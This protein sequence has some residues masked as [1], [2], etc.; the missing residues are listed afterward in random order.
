MRA[1]LCAVSLRCVYYSTFT[2]WSQ[3]PCKVGNICDIGEELSSY[4]IPL[5]PSVA[6]FIFGGCCY[7]ASACPFE[8][9]KVFSVFLVNA[10]CAGGDFM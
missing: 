4:F 3:R 8:F 2:C 9:T 10:T 6:A 5:W 1:V 7:D